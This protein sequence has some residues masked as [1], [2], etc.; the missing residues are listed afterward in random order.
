MRPRTFEEGPRLSR[1]H[2]PAP[3][4]SAPLRATEALRC[5]GRLAGERRH[6]AT[7]GS[8]ARCPGASRRRPRRR[9][10]RGAS[11][12]ALAAAAPAA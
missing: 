5:Y 6:V 2:S 1:T 10:A 3:A 11:P 7:V 9:P 12:A 4:G 8:I